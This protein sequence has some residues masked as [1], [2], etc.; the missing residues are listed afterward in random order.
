MMELNIGLI[1]GLSIR[2][3]LW[4]LCVLEKFES[5]IIFLYGKIVCDEK[6]F[7]CLVIEKQWVEMVESI[8][9]EIVLLDKQFNFMGQVKKIIQIKGNVVIFVMDGS[10]IVI[11][12]FK[13]EFIILYFIYDYIFF[14][15]FFYIKDLNDYQLFK[16]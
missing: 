11:N 3:N 4:V 16:D 7:W 5:L 12:V 6:G 13:C 10:D 14:L 15:V 8:V 1:Y 2:L 9:M